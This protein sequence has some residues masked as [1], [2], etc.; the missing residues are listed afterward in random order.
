MMMKST[1]PVLEI[2]AL[3]DEGL[4]S[5][6]GSVF[7]VKDSYG[8]IVMPGAF[9]KSLTS[10]RKAKSRPAMLWM[11]DMKEPVGSWS[12]MAEDEKGLYVEGSLNMDV[13]R[14]REIYSLLKRGDIA[15][16]S[17]GYYEVKATDDETQ[18]ARLLKQ[19]DLVEVSIVSIGA[20]PAALVGGVKSLEEIRAAFAKGET[21]RLDTIEECLRDAGFPK[22]LAT[23][24]VSAGKAAFRRSDSGAEASDA[25][26][27]LRA[28]SKP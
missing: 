1:S 28:L 14:A 22:A 24:F 27:F 11:H 16:L 21:P 6:Y 18:A 19:L 20:N 12:Q 5:G 23:A 3:S 2:K 7:G 13:Q 4:F 15:G 10:H 17:I 8:D 26:E 25:L 9:A